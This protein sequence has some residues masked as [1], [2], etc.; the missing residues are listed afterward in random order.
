MNSTSLPDSAPS[1]ADLGTLVVL[2]WS[3]QHPTEPGDMPF[4]LA[5]SLGDGP[6]GPEGASAAVRAFL[7]SAGLPV[8][9][10]VLDGTHRSLPVT[11]LVQAGQAVLT[12]DRLNA[13]C[14]VPPEWLDAVGQRGHACLMFATR[15]WPAGRPGLAVTADELTA[16]AG[17]PETVGTAAHCLVPVRSLRG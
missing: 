1:T 14:P 2:A 11:L 7:D 3:G 4:L 9:G 16:F 5:Y 17:S 12:L 13:Q 6:G 10:P 8:G 15:P